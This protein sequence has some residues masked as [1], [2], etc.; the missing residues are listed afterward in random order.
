M[1]LNLEQEDLKLIAKDVSEALKP[2]LK[3]NTKSSASDTILNV[4]ELAGYL[5]VNESWV[6]EKV[7]FKEIPYF[8]CGKYLRFRKS[9]I[10]KW[11]DKR[12]I[13]TVPALSL[14]DNS[15]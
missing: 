1:K 4:K 2:L 7:Q 3:K 13:Q 5:N 11:I 6:Y 14:V 8:K 9:S 15:R 10:D 12:T